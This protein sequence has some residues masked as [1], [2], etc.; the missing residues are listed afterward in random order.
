[1]GKSEKQ[2]AKACAW[3]WFSKYIR[4]R[5]CLRTTGDLKTG[6]C[7]SCGNTVRFEKLDAGH[8]VPGRGDSV[9]FEP[10][11]CHAQCGPC[12]RFKQGA[13]VPYFY[14]VNDLYGRDEAQRLMGLY[15]IKLSYTSEEY[16]EFADIYRGQYKELCNG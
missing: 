15:F 4:A 8:F 13:W 11:N 7:I 12:N 1:M 16:R 3:R 6:V 9:I 5:D 2:R 14:A 10:T